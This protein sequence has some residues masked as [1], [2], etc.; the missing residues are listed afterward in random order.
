MAE[1]CPVPHA[2]AWSACFWEGP[3]SAYGE[4]MASLGTTWLLG[5]RGGRPRLML[6]YKPH[7]C[8][9]HQG[10]SSSGNTFK[11]RLN[12]CFILQIIQKNGLWTRSTDSVSGPSVR[13]AWVTKN[14]D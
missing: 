2:G 5:K 1:A 12:D 9:C 11:E 13:V 7:T 4:A 6:P 10:L 3:R 8:E 14:I